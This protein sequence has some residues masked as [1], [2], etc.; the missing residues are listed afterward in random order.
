MPSSSALR[1]L[2]FVLALLACASV[3][4]REHL[5]AGDIAPTFVGTNREF[6]PVSLES[7]VGKVVVI[8]LW[9][10]WC[11]PCLKEMPILD[12]IQR[13]AGQRQIQVIAINTET[14]DVYRQVAKRLAEF[15]LMMTHDTGKK[16]SDA[17]GVNGIPHMVIIGRD[18]RIVRVNRGYNE[19]G[20]DAIVADI[21]RALVAK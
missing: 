2:T 7:Y 13:S 18:G 1:R 6:E 17:Y 19:Q 10:S 20:L 3:H 11:P 12:G 8:S 14:P 5:V 21:N 16:A 15:D 4:A 9:A